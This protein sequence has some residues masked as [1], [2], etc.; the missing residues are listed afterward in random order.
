MTRR[1]RE[2]R[3]ITVMLPGGDSAR[4]FGSDYD[5]ETCTLDSAPRDVIDS[6]GSLYKLARKLRKAL[7][8]HYDDLSTVMVVG[9]GLDNMVL[10]VSAIVEG[11]DD[12]DPQYTQP[13]WKVEEDIEITVDSL[14]HTLWSM[15]EE[16]LVRP[17][18]YE[19]M[20]SDIG[21][22]TSISEGTLRPEDLIEAFLGPLYLLDPRTA[23]EIEEKY[24]E[25]VNIYDRHPEDL[26]TLEELF[27]ALNDVAPDGYYFGAAMG[28][29]S[30]FGFW[31]AEEE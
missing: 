31:K 16:W 26:E 19:R 22:G 11:D 4:M 8:E 27:Y 18:Y 6:E 20:F 9:A 15:P 29:A 17:R 24:P 21:E 12:D 2:I 13:R 30:D 1:D 7:E 28:N 23:R 25:I 3:L 10:K 5:V 14:F